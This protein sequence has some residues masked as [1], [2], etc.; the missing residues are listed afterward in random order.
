V[1]RGA[2][3]QSPDPRFDLTAS[4]S[5]CEICLQ[6]AQRVAL[7]EMSQSTGGIAV[8]ERDFSDTGRQ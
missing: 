2:T 7:V 6:Y 1:R 5:H 3:W 8:V 4:L